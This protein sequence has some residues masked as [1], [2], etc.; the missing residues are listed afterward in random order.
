MKTTREI[1]EF[2][3]RMAAQPTPS[4]NEPQRSAD[5]PIEVQS[6]GKVLAFPKSLS[7]DAS[8]TRSPGLSHARLLPFVAQVCPSDPRYCVYVYM[9]F[10]YYCGRWR[11]RFLEKDLHTLLPRTLNLATAEEVIA[12][13][14]RGGGLSNLEVRQALDLAIA[15]RRGDVFLTLTTDQYSQLQ[16]H[17]RPTSARSNAGRVRVL[18]P[19]ACKTPR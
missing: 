13:A 1:F 15:N 10:Q 5:L 8:I 11:C 14:D 9:S 19:P 2:G 4:S 3:P 17:C 6:S 12:L 16:I 18:S 7:Q